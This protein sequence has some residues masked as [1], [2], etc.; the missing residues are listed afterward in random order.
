MSLYV[1]YA[2]LENFTD[3]GAQ[4]ATV[5]EVTESWSR[6]SA[7]LHTHTHTRAH[8]QCLCMSWITHAHFSPA[9][10]KNVRNPFL[11]FEVLIPKATLHTNY[12]T[13]QD[14]SRKQMI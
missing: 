10:C 12:C 5:H 7:H 13:S 11:K 9:L 1:M 2:C 14:P 3:R 8:T 6:L 4:Q